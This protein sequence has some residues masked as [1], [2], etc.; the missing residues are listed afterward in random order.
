MKSNSAAVSTD[1]AALNIEKVSWSTIAALALPALGALIA[2]PLF[3]LVDSVFISHVST[4]ALAGLGLASTILTTVV[5]LAIFLAYSTT[6][7]VAR[8][9]GAGNLTKAVRL[10][11]DASWLGFAIGIASA[12]F[13]ALLAE[14]IIELFNPTPDVSNQALIYLLI[15]TLG[16]PAMLLIQAALG[17]VRGLQNT[18]ITLLIAALGA[19]ANIPLN[20]FLIFSLNLG[21]VGSAIGTVIAQWGM[22]SC[23]LIIIIKGANRYEASLKPQL[24]GIRSSWSDA[25]WLFIRTASLRIVLLIAAAVAAK[26]GEVTLAAHQ[27]VNSIFALSALALDSLAIAAQALTGKY[28]GAKNVPAVR[29]ITRSLIKAAVLGGFIVA[30][31]LWLIAWFAPGLLSPDPAVQNALFWGMLAL[32]IA[33]P[34]AGYVFVL[35]GILMGA[36]DSRYLGIAGIFTMLTYIPFAAALWWWADQGLPAPNF[37]FRQDETAF[38]LSM[39]WLCFTGVLLTSRALTLWWRIRTD[40]WMHLA[41]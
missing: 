3:V 40:E 11:I 2:E 21:I 19:A 34:L 7:Q 41:D 31:I 29:S 17:L 6:A 27:L 24:Q 30:G 32:L 35:D 33:Q 1:A 38:G 28:L 15:S 23:Y 37:I 9:V 39:L 16:L 22:A 26:L 4:A 8:A 18:K 36:A 25:K 10:G 12:V 5:G 14:P 20:W 13:L